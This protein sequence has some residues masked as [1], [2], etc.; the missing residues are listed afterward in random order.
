MKAHS[1]SLWGEER[2]T[3][4][5]AMVLTIEA[6]QA[7]ASAYPHWVVAFSGGKDSTTVATFLMHLI[8]TGHLQACD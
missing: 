6:M 1:V 2:L 3:L 8:E 5:Q 4:E 7:H